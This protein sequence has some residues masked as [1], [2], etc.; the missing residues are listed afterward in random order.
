MPYTKGM[1][2]AADQLPGHRIVYFCTLEAVGSFVRLVFYGVASLIA[3]Y[4]GNSKAFFFGL[5]VV[6][7]V[8]SLVIMREKF[9]ALKP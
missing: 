5:F 3:F 4:Y 8:A 6:G 9:V 2:D 7:S 1:Y